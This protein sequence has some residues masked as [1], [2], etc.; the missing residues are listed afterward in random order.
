LDK[1][2]LTKWLM[3]AD[4]ARLIVWIIIMVVL[5]CVAEGSLH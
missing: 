2:K 3:H 1:P 4:Q 5:C